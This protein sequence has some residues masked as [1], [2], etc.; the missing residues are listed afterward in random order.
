MSSTHPKD[1]AAAL[2]DDLLPFAKQMLASHGEFYPY[3]GFM[4][5]DGAIVHAGATDP[6]TD[7]PESA[8]LI[9]TLTENFRGQAQRGEIRAAAI[10]FDV[11]VPL[12]DTPEKS[13]AIQ[14][15]LEHASSY[16]AEVFF[17]YRWS[18]GGGVEFGET[19]AQEGRRMIFGD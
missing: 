11:L 15:N 6:A 7:R 8:K 19:F 1:D 18:D 16:A 9:D 5:T 13:E 14:V 17:P 4:R 2:L 3:G 10:V 12:P